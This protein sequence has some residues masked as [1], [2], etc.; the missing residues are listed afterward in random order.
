MSDDDQT[1]F[2]TAVLSVTLTEPLTRAE[3]CRWHR[4]HPNRWATLAAALPGLVEVGGKVRVPLA[5]M[6]P[7]YVAAKLESPI[8]TVPQKAAERGSADRGSAG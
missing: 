4:W 8:L 7:R 6:P 2:W 3:I 1:A 5:L